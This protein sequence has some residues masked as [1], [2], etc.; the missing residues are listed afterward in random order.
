VRFTLTAIKDGITAPIA[1]TTKTWVQRVYWDA[2]VQPGVF[3][4]AFVLS[5]LAAYPGSLVSGELHNTKNLTWTV[6][7]GGMVDNKHIYCAY[8]D[9]YGDS[10]FWVGGFEG[11][12]ALVATVPVTNAHGVTENY[13]I[14]ESINVGLGVTEVTVTDPA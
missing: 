5:L 1:Q 10:R 4:A 3:N 2:Q 12:F 11:G 6:D 9:A 14:Y 8:R 7:A 13:R